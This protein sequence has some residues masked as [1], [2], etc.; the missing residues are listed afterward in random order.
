MFVFLP[1]LT[2]FLEKMTVDNENRMNDIASS[3]LSKYLSLEFI[4]ASP[5]TKTLNKKQ[6]VEVEEKEEPKETAFTKLV[7]REYQYELYQKAL[8]ENIIVVLD[9]GM[10]KT[11]ISTMLIKQMVLNERQARLTRGKVTHNLYWCAHHSN[12]KLIGCEAET[13]VLHSRPRPSSISTSKCY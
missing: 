5:E 4:N 2:I 9:T 7:P 11:L 3:E 1:A 6:V 10:G 13:S 12:K 8:H